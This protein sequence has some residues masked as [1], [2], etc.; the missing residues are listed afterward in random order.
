MVILLLVVE[1]S[2]VLSSTPPTPRPS[3]LLA[4]PTS[5]MPWPSIRGEA[6]G[7]LISEGRLVD[8]GSN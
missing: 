4:P 6:A 8:H 1:G 5:L 3:T 7:G 2:M